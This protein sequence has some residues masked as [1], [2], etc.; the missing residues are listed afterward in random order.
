M[1]VCVCAIV[2]FFL[3]SFYSH[4]GVVG[5]IDSDVNPSSSPSS[6]SSLSHQ[7]VVG[8]VVL[9]EVASPSSSVSSSSSYIVG[10]YV[11]DGVGA[12]D[13]GDGDDNDDGDDDNDVMDDGA[14]DGEDN[15][16][17]EDDGASEEDTNSSFSFA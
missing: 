17:S 5:T 6:L 4:Q 3:N 12:S 8:F 2:S 7:C 15:G 10:K 14:A 11:G 16:A 1:C 13:G 9:S